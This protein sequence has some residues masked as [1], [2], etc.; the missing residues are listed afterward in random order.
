MWEA[1][2]NPDVDEHL[3]QW[4]EA[5]AADPVPQP[6]AATAADIW[7][8]AELL[9]RWDAQRK[10]AAPIEVGERAQVGVGLVGALVLL[11]W[12]SRQLPANSISPALAAALVATVLLLVS[13]AAFSIWALLSRE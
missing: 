12:A 11:V 10:A 9:R 8:K 7:Q 3:A 5:L 6:P 2:L 4:M 13:A 1:P